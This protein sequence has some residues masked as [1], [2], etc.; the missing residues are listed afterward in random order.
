MNSNLNLKNISLSY[1]D[2][3]DFS[4]SISPERNAIPDKALNKSIARYGI[5]HPPLVRRG[6][7]GLYNIIAGRKRLLTVRSFQTE[8][9][10]FCRVIS[11]QIP[12]IDVFH[13]LL[14]EIQLTRQL[15]T[16]EKAIFLQKIAAITDE[17]YIIREFL[18][19]LGLVPKSFSIQR[20][21]KL[22]DLEEPII[23]NIHHGRI[24]EQVAHDLMLLSSQDRMVLFEIITTLRLSGSYQ[25]KLLNICRDLANRSNTSIAVLLNNDEVHDILHHQEA[26][27]PQKTKN[28]MFWLSRKHMPRYGQA[29]D[30]F[31]RFMTE[32]HLPP[33]VSVAH[34]PFFEDDSMTLTITFP[35]RKSLQ[36][37]WKKIR[38][39]T[40]NSDD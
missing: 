28:L 2:F 16:I 39:T 40:Q 29:A 3:E 36:Y 15:T 13:I 21:L 18:P 9:I 32:M 4:Y 26:N 11:R 33:N 35:N 14:E 23:Q 7:S 38:H 19:L 37:A 10:C 30:E 8:N 5:L 1:I 20:A 27:P 31:S 25:K 24:N 22:L 12:E 17:K 34:T 6:D